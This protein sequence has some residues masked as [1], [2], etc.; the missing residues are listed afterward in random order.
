M[1][2]IKA[3]LNKRN[4]R[5]FRWNK[6]YNFI[7]YKSISLT[8]SNF[9]IEKIIFISSFPSEY[10]KTLFYVYKEYD[11]NIFLR[12]MYKK[13]YNNFIMSVVVPYPSIENFG[14]RENIRYPFF[15][16]ST[17]LEAWKP[18]NHEIVVAS[19]CM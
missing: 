6:S 13:Y 12:L 16:I 17:R 1:T 2:F 19:G 18:K 15:E 9:F 3:Q 5:I 10:S 8:A 14:I 11:K 7:F 4:E